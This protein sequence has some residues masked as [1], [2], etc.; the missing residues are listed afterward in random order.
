MGDASGL[1][2]FAIRAAPQGIYPAVCHVGDAYVPL[3]EE[4]LARLRAVADAP[5]DQLYAVLVEVVGVSTY[6]KTRIEQLW[7]TVDAGAQSRL[8]QEAIK[9]LAP[10]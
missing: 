8:L 5:P 7:Q 4:G 3:S 2:G 10:Q 9:R 6:M 1:K